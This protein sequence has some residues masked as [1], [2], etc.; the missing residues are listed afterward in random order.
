MVAISDP[1]QESKI[2]QP[3]QDNAQKSSQA[4]R[5]VETPLYTL[6]LWVLPF[7]CTVPLFGMFGSLH[8]PFDHRDPSAWEGI[9]IWYLKWGTEAYTWG[10][11]GIEIT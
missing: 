5:S 7:A 8:N 4:A 9:W 2:Q 1:A 6:L 10:T 3:F 11:E